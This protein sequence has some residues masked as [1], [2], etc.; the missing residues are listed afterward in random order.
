MFASQNVDCE[1]SVRRG[2]K[3]SSSA[4]DADLVFDLGAHV[5]Q[6]IDTHAHL[7][8]DDFQSD[9]PGVIQRAGAVG[10]QAMIAV[11][12]D[13]PS[14]NQCL[15]LADRYAEIYATAGVHPNHLLE[16]GE[17]DWD[18]V[19]QLGQHELVVAWGETGL[20]RY[21][22]DVPFDLQVQWFHRHLAA[23]RENNKPAIIHTR[24]CDVDIVRELK[25]AVADGPVRGVMH[26]FTG[27]LETAEFCLQ[28]G[29]YISF[30]GMVT[31][32]KSKELLAIAQRIPD[33]RI[34]VET[35]SPFLSPEPFRGKKPNEPAR[36]IYTARVIA[37]ARG[38][39]LEEFAELTTAN[40]RRLFSLSKRPNR[41]T[42]R[43]GVSG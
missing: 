39:T 19:K 10:V 18:Q 16:V 12:T 29:L 30:A 24:D 25:A 2:S 17:H 11:A 3:L 20:D 43:S 37:A 4:D 14:S 33:D 27:T 26:S 36:V 38:Q 9:L 35:D 40:A 34:L 7:S 21:W 1:A 28:Q 31:F 32:K 6:L 42:D 8:Y 22:Q 15:A 5:L 41:L 23:S 13:L